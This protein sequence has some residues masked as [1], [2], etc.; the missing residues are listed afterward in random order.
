MAAPALS[1]NGLPPAGLRAAPTAEW[2]SLLT[3]TDPELRAEGFLHLAGR[4]ERLSGPAETEAA[5]SLY[6]ELSHGAETPAGV[7]RRAAEPLEV[8]S[9]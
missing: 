8:L 6:R 5:F 1:F 2:R 9:G 3:E 7:V 4:L